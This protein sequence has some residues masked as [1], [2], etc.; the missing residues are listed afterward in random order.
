MQNTLKYLVILISI[1]LYAQLALAEIAPF[2]IEVNAQKNTVRSGEP[3]ILNIVLKNTSQRALIIRP[4]RRLYKISVIT[5]T[6]GVSASKTRRQQ[7]LE[8]APLRFNGIPDELKPGETQ[9]HEILLNEIY[10]MNTPGTYVIRVE[11]DVWKGQADTFLGT[12][13]LSNLI[14]VTVTQ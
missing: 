5:A 3:V 4:S 13:V 8:A 10:N 7:E 14:R 2:S 9:E 6:S 11:R 12:A 1:G